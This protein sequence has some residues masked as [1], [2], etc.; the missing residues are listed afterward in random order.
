MRSKQ[1]LSCAAALQA[2]VVVASV[3]CAPARAG[4]TVSYFHNDV[5]GSP[6]MATDI[7]GLLTWK[8][9]YRPYGDRLVQS[10]AARGNQ[11]W[12]A[13]KPFDAETGLSYAGARYYD[14][15]LGRFMGIDPMQATET[16]LHS[17][18]R[19]AYASN[20]PLRYVDPTGM[21]SLGVNGGFLGVSFGRDEYSSQ[22]FWELKAGLTGI[23]VTFDPSNN[24]PGGE[25]RYERECLECWVDS[26]QWTTGN[27]KAG[28]VVGPLSWQ[29]IEYD[30][31]ALIV[32]D[33]VGGEDH[34]YFEDGEGLKTNWLDLESSTDGGEFG[35]DIDLEANLEFGGTFSWDA[36]RSLFGLPPL[37]TKVP[38]RRPDGSSGPRGE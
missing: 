10:T 32:D 21:W 22:F 7:N 23:G 30:V 11:L 33:V 25:G 27:I 34:A 29:P 4:E 5:A 35:L 18:N 19:Y 26:T 6:M 28:L 3:V 24:A 36:F 8:E 14:P 13:G 20:N 31:G 38:E 1:R 9:T 2:A 12:F 15:T 17:F 37:Q 16:N